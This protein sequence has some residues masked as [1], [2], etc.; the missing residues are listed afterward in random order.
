MCTIELSR[1]GWLNDLGKPLTFEEWCG[2]YVCDADDEENKGVIGLK[3]GQYQLE[4]ISGSWP[5]LDDEKYHK[6]RNPVVLPIDIKQCA[7]HDEYSSKEENMTKEQMFEVSEQCKVNYCRRRCFFRQQRW[8]QLKNGEFHS[9]NWV[10]RRCNSDA[11]CNFEDESPSEWTN[12]CKNGWCENELGV[13]AEFWRREPMSYDYVVYNAE[14]WTH[15]DNGCRYFAVHNLEKTTAFNFQTHYG[16]RA[17]C[18]MWVDTPVNFVE[19]DNQP[20]LTIYT[21]ESECFQNRESVE[22]TMTT[23]A[24]TS[25]TYPSPLPEIEM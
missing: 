21:F 17:H 11:Q 6:R 20:E 4:P 25:S 14:D 3:T 8:E 15:V 12:T 13:L 23:T 16:G 22:T 7:V 19:D 9:K 18:F 24:L 10:T 5:H 2:E 1:E